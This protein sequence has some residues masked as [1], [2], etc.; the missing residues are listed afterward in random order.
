MP[1]CQCLSNVSVHFRLVFFREND[2]LSY[3]L[4]VETKIG[5]IAS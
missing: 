2:G 4:S 1:A 5:S 3:L